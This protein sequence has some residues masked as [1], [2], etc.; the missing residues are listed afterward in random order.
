ML[1]LSILI[2]T[3]NRANKLNRILKNIETEVAKIDAMH[4]MEVIISDNASSDETKHSVESF[5]SNNYSIRYFRQD[6]NIGFDRNIKFLYEKSKG[7]Y[8]WYVSDDDILLPGAIQEVVNG[9]KA[10]KPDVMLFSFEQ[11]PGSTN[12]TFDLPELVSLVTDPK[13]IISLVAHFPKITIY[14]MR[15]IELTEK[16]WAEIE[17]FFDDGYFFVVLC[18]SILNRSKQARLSIISKTLAVCDDDFYCITYSPN[19]FLNF[20]RVFL[21]S[22]VQKHLPNLANESRRTSYFSAIQLMFAI[23]LGTIRTDNEKQFD[24]DLNSFKVI[25]SY[26]VLNPRPM[27]QL[28]ILKTGLVQLYKF[29]KILKKPLLIKKI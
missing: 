21:H 20:Y 28:I 10:T 4:F 16:D 12:K 19:V 17:T 11:P 3:Y 9:L 6:E 5:E 14:V 13:I 7:D 18:Y 24:K 29:L 8:V 25:P 15:K 27:V 22:F 2:P 1:K 23:K 26:L